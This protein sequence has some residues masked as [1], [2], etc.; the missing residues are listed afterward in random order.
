[1][2]SSLPG[3]PQEVGKKRCYNESTMKK[4]LITGLIGVAALAGVSV[5]S[6]QEEAKTNSDASL[7]GTQGIK[8]EVGEESSA[9][10]GTGKEY[11][12]CMSKAVD[13][14]E[15]ALIS[16]IQTY[17]TAVISARTTYKSAAV[18]AWNSS[19]DRTTV[20]TALKT[21]EKTMK[22]SLSIAEKNQ[23]VAR[24]SASRQFNADRTACLKLSTTAVNNGNSNPTI[25]SL[26]DMI[27][28]LQ[29]ELQKLK[30]GSKQQPTVQRQESPENNLETES[31][32]NSR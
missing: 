15:S 30:N 19:E 1:M 13:T 26:L 10:Q 17:Q 18:S 5:A 24:E 29:S 21:A 22:D 7:P 9:V 2:L 8:L 25:Q 3:F 20:Q 11:L 4:L 16:S 14:R 28:R 12:S 23:T 31:G 32:A 27:K 6:A